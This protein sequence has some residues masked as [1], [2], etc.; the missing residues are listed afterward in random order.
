VI[1]PD[2]GLS[3]FFQGHGVVVSLMM[4]I[5]RWANDIW[6]LRMFEVWQ[7]SQVSTDY[8]DYRHSSRGMRGTQV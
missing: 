8:T 3:I 7:P 6:F 2:T 1:S 4:R 5:A